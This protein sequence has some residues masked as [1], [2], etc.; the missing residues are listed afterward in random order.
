MSGATPPPATAL[1]TEAGLP[2]ARMATISDPTTPRV[3]PPLVSASEFDI[4]L[5]TPAMIGGDQ[6]TTSP[7]TFFGSWAP[8]LSNAPQVLLVRVSPQ[9]EESFWKML[10]R[11][12]A[13]TQGVALPPLASFSANFLRMR[14]YCGGA[15]VTPIHRFI[16][17]MPIEG[18]KPV[19]EGLYVYALTDFGLHCPSVRVELFSEK[20]PNKPDRR[21]IDP[22]LF[23]Q[24]AGL[25]R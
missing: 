16:I 6:G 19:R 21:T 18:R 12:A 3:Q 25:S 10:A 23:T 14:A 2:P 15:E 24:I 11:G 13:R 7:R 5:V 9:F 4:S 8:Y 20:S 22:K 1:R 17:E